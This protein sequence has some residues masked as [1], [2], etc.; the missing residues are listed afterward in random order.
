MINFGG[1]RGSGVWIRVDVVDWSVA[2]VLDNSVTCSD[3]EEA[4]AVLG[5]E[6]LHLLG[7][8]REFGRH[9][10]FFVNVRKLVEDSLILDLPVLEEE[11]EG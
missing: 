8:D 9:F 4:L 5:V 6:W 1:S 3:S 10:I 2:M 11:V 7:L